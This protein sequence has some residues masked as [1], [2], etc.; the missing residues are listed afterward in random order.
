MMMSAARYTTATRSIRVFFRMRSGAAKSVT[1]CMYRAAIQSRVDK[2]PPPSAN[3]PT[4]WYTVVWRK[5]RI[6]IKTNVTPMN[7]RNMATAIVIVENSIAVWNRAKL[8]RLTSY[9]IAMRRM[10]KMAGYRFF[11]SVS[12]RTWGNAGCFE[13]VP[14]EFPEM[15]ADAIIASPGSPL[16]RK[17][18]GCA[19]F[20]RNQRGIFPDFP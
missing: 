7:R 15:S 17:F 14:E 16:Y 13:G 6:A 1:A 2:V 19:S 4:P 18:S 9:R 20:T 8:Y 12:Y 11:R 10:R 5:S 3:M